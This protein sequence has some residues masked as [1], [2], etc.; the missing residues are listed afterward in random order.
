MIEVDILIFEHYVLIHRIN[1]CDLAYNGHRIIEGTI[2][3]KAD[4]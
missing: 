4:F 3:W 1:I 2:L